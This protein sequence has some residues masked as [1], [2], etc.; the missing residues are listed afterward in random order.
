[1]Q[2]SMS[3][4]K[5]LRLRGESIIMLYG[6]EQTAGRCVS[7]V[8][9]YWPVLNSVGD[10][11]PTNSGKSTVYNQTKHVPVHCRTILQVPALVDWRG[12]VDRIDLLP[13]V[14]PLCRRQIGIA[15]TVKASCFQGRLYSP[16]VQ[17]AD[18]T[19]SDLSLPPL[20]PHPPSQIQAT[21]SIDPLELSTR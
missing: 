7:T 3:K 5:R 19:S 12:K 4:G 15:T 16:K 8:G 14:G 9:R 1:M 6:S 18:F 10:R 20:H 11:E 17:N 21:N 13:F 2:T